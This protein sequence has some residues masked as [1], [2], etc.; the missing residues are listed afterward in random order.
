MPTLVIFGAGD[1]GGTVARQTAAAGPVRRIVLVDDAASASAG[2]ALDQ[3]QAAPIDGYSTRISGTADES[4]A[5][6]ASLI[7]IADRF[8]ASSTE[9]SGEAGLALVGRLARMAPAVPIVC[10]GASQSPLVEGGVHELGIDRS[11]LIG[12]APEALRAAVIA[13]TAL[14]AGCAPSEIS[15]VV[16][17]RP[18]GWVVPWDDA[19]IGGRRATGVL[20]A[21]ALLRLDDRV[22]RLWPPGPRTLGGAATLVI[23]AALSRVPR[24]PAVFV[25]PDTLAGVGRPGDAPGVSRRATALP[26]VLGPSGVQRI[27][28]PR[29]GTRDRVRLETAIQA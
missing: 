11:R 25:I 6:D 20:D 28:M 13:M 10:A 15:L 21:P 22:A 7:V 4:A 27:D 8:G 12:S 29:L 23:R 19:S 18:G 17:G 26:V 14:E 1:L 5:L 16:L 24:Q 9:W 2:K 3:M